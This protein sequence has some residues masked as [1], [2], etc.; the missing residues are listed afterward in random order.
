MSPPDTIRVV[1]GFSKDAY[2]Y[3]PILIVGAGESAIALGARLKEEGFD[4]FRLFERQAGIGGTWWINRY[5]GVACD[6]YHHTNISN[7]CF[8]L[9]TEPKTG[10]QHSTPSPS[11][12]I[13]NGQVSIQRAKKSTTTL[14]ISPKST[15]L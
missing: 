8:S 5:P 3:Y 15:S 7:S 10:Q 2:T 6:V 9:L 4:Q 12:L 14:N 1:N 11:L 13:T